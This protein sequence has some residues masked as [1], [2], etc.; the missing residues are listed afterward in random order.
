MDNYKGIYYKETKE[1]K[2]YEGGAHFPYKVLFNILLKLGGTLIQDE[3]TNNYKCYDL[4]YNI[5]KNLQEKI[6]IKYKTRNL[7]Q[8]DDIYRNNPNTLI[9]YPSQNVINKENSKKKYASRNEKNSLYNGYTFLNNKNYTTS[10]NVGQSKKN[11]DNH[12]LQI[13]LNKKEKEKHNDEK[14]NEESSNDNRYSIMNFYNNTHYRNRSE[15]YSNI[16][17]NKKIKVNNIEKIQ[18]N[19]KNDF[20]SYI[21]NKINLIK[22]NKIK[23]YPLEINGKIVETKENNVLDNKNNKNDLEIREKQRN[24]PYLNY[25]DNIPKK[26]RNIGN[27]NIMEYKN[28]FE[29]NKNATGN[30]SKKY[31]NKYLFKT[32]DNFNQEN[33]INNY[34]KYN[35]NEQK[36]FSNYYGNNI[37][38]K[39]NVNKQAIN[40]EPK[41]N[42]FGTQKYKRKKINQL[43][44]FNQNNGKSKIW[45]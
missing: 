6:R 43:S 41:E 33:I 24:K 8:K 40:E 28:T 36:N 20:P 13:L 5:T 9:K 2:Y 25:F 16:E 37:S 3:I 34:M 39:I 10:I 45:K 27:N 15:Y 21:R 12:L 31:V 26:S 29:N 38:K 19:T 32:S 17:N 1:Q 44:C 11:I 42:N 23:K 7:E 22:S 18:E 14:N 30:Y 4:N 35:I